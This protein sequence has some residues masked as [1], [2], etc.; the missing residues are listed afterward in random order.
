[1]RSPGIAQFH[2]FFP[3]G[4]VRGRFCRGHD[5]GRKESVPC[6]FSPPPLVGPSHFSLKTSEPHN[7]KK[8][9]RK[10]FQ[11]HKY[12]RNKTRQSCHTIHKPYSIHHAPSPQI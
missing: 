3:V 12:W 10:I 11:I 5:S 7:N 4:W 1:M 6:N 9:T 2:F 8:L